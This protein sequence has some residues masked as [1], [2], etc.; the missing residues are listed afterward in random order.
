MASDTKSI[1]PIGGAWYAAGTS[2]AVRARLS[3]GADGRWEITDEAGIGLTSGDHAAVSVSARVGSIPRRVSFPDGSSFET[4][5]NDAVDRLL[6]SSGRRHSGLI[7]SLE[8]FHPR[9]AIFVVLVVLLGVGIYR[10][11]VPALVEVAIA[12]TPPVVPEL[13]SRSVMASLDQTVFG[14][15]QLDAETQRDIAAGF[16]RL[17]GFAAQGADAF[18]LNFRK[19]GPIGPNAFA[20]P[21][22]TLVLTDELVELADDEEAILGVLAHEI[23]HV[24]LQHSLRQLYRAAGV[25]GLIFLIGGDI[26]AGTEDI[27]IQGAA[28]ASL[29][30]S[31][32]A[33]AEADRYSVRLMLDAGRDPMAIVRFLE[34]LRDRLHDTSEADFLSSHPATPTR[35]EETRQYAEK[36]MAERET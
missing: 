5:D 24:E 25:T 1:Q 29:S 20:L 17:A 22:G 9:L 13:L 27:L 14:P 21:D 36:L 33:E 23:G 26:G 34:L 35:I 11:A 10:Y 30:Y 15:S 7:H 3:P 8:R 4:D 19:G 16:Q 31:R 12:V 2:R 18:T 28:L 32:A 6:T